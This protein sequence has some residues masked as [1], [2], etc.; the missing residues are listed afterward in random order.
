[1]VIATL[2]QHTDCSDLESAI[3]SDLKLKLLRGA[4]QGEAVTSDRF[5]FTQLC[6]P[7][8]EEQLP[9]NDQLVLMTRLHCDCWSTL[10]SANSSRRE[11]QRWRNI[12]REMLYRIERFGLLIHFGDSSDRFLVAGPEFRSMR[13]RECLDGLR[14]DTLYKITMN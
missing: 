10:A 8:V 1:M 9:C 14:R 12:F 7:S 13:D 6:N 3:P 4:L 11:L 2:P 5:G